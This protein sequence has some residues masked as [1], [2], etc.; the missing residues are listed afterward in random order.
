[1]KKTVLFSILIIILSTTNLQAQGTKIVPGFKQKGNI[2]YYIDR[3]DGR[4]LASGETLDNTAFVASHHSIP[5]D[6]KVKVTNLKNGK[7]VIVRVNDRGPYAHGRIMDVSKAAAKAIG[8][9]STGVSKAEIEVLNPDGTVPSEIAKE[10]DENNNNVAPLAS[11]ATTAKDYR[12]NNIY[13]EWGSVRTPEGYGVQLGG[14]EKFENAKKYCKKIRANGLGQHELIF[15]R[16]TYH[17]GK[18]WFQIVA[19]KYTSEMAAESKISYFRK[20]TGQ[21][22]FATPYSK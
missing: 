17:N 10:K 15:I 6:T 4:Q 18:K 13:S 8:L 21:T 2:S 5:F 12:V 11:N 19:G 9:T 16:V 7:S 1:M 14:F 3:F 20:Y 22:G